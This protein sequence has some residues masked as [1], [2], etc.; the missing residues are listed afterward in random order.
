[1]LFDLAKYYKTAGRTEE[2]FEK[3]RIIITNPLYAAYE[4]SAAFLMADTYSSID[5]K[6]EA[7]DFLKNLA[8]ETSDSLRAQKYLLK[9]G[10]LYEHWNIYETA[11]SWYDS[12]F[13]M[14]ISPDLSVQALMGIGGVFKKID[15]WMDSG[16]TYERIILEYPDNPH[17]K[18]VY[19]ALSDVYLL[20]GRLKIAALT[21]EKAVKYADSKEKIDI[22][23]YIADLYEEIDENHALQLYTI[24]FN[25]N[26]NSL[27]QISEALLKYGDIALRMGDSES[28]V[29]AYATV[30]INDADSVSISRAQEKLGYINEIPDDIN[31]NVSDQ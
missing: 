17:I 19:L 23:L 28:A 9:I 3:Y 6:N 31:N 8:Y 25:N 22:L 5:K 1:M 18:D 16:K 21:A 13:A 12:S 15:R 24:I 7:V 11:I 14:Q 27:S 30:I 4:D 20:E 10:S 26:R 2:A 29:K